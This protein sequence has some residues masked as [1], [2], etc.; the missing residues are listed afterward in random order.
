LIA[1]PSVNEFQYSYSPG[2]AG[3]FETLGKPKFPKLN[4]SSVPLKISNYF[5][6]LAPSVYSE[7]KTPTGASTTS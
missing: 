6:L 7:K 5:L 2:V 4:T 1:A 3:A